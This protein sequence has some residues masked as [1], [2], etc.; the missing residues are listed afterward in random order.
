MYLIKERDYDYISNKYHDTSKPWN[1]FGR[2]VRRDEIFSPET[3]MSPEDILTGIWENDK[4]Y[5]N[6]PHPIRKA[7][8]LAYVLK[9]TRISCDR[10]DIFPA[11]NM[12]DR[13]LKDT[14]IKKWK[15][16]IF[17]EV[18]PEVEK[19]RKQLE[20][21][22]IVTIWPDYDHSV[23]M[24]DRLFDLGFPGLLE[25]S[26]RARQ[27]RAL[28]AEQKAFY[29]GVRITYEGVLAFIDR[30]YELADANE[31]SEKMA[32][33]LKNIRTGAPNS[34]YEAML[35]SYIYF[36][37]SEQVDSLQVRSLSNF[38]RQYYKFYKA[39]LERG[40]SEEEIRTDLAYFFM[41][42]TAIGNY[43][44]QPVYLGG[45]NAD[46]STVIGELSYL[47]LDVYDKM[48]IYNP[49]VQIKVA[50]NTPKEFLQKALDMIRR[51]H[52]S[53]VF[54]SDAVMRRSLIKVGATE[55][56]AR[57]CDV[58]GCYEYSVQGAYNSGMNYLN[59]LKP[60]EYA[61][62]EGRDGV[63]GIMAG[64]SC[65]S[66]SE[67]KSFDDLYAEYKRQLLNV[68]NLT[69]ET[70]NSFEDYLCEVS[71]LSF[72]SATLD[73]CIEQGR[74][75]IGG[76]ALFNG[77]GLS[78]GYLADIA[79]S[80]AMIQKYVFERGE[81]TLA[82]FVGMLDNNY[83]GNEAFRLKLRADREKY[84][85][86]KE[87][88]D[89]IAVDIVDFI[90]KNTCGR[91]NAERRG[92]TWNCSFHTAR[93]SYVQG[94]KTASSPNGRLLGEELS[95][96]ISASMGQNRE[97][98]TAAVL[99]ATKIEASSFTSDSNLDMGL[100]PSAVSGEDGLEA[101]YGLLLTYMARGGK[102]MQIN[103][104]DA[105]TLRDA[106]AHPEKYGDLQIRVCGWNVL[107][108]NICK[109]EQDGFIRQAEGLV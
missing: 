50:D 19:K 2:F 31:G 93:M 73:S 59:L 52:N 41:Q 44:N 88:P 91:P 109:E 42:F 49:K 80:L 8:A 6:E 39:D 89:R 84:G 23:P 82:E 47:F 64:L 56:Q 17:K 29:E 100:L 53:I 10:R 54:V 68:I 67:Y 58:K 24:W 90:V 61:L 71:P 65:P 75:A 87:R 12:V 108:N 106:Q 27:G 13:P 40:V 92:G 98:A 83:E 57:L 102:S 62:H 72:M 105:D 18:I 43:W 26:E 4:K 11:I 66:P 9:N 25:R 15:N 48:G 69:I 55:E 101:M 104:F 81:L 33:A 79:D 46:G 14:I 38:D 96:N 63:T 21:D 45:E 32:A 37:I 95:K 76:G 70:V 1:G 94:K 28:T 77:S 86:N 107:W 35:V 97:G 103:V 5:E 22:G 20:T 51:G 30:L 85:N 99:S 7:H 34:F 16:E 3:G 36:M 78:P 74:D 60:L